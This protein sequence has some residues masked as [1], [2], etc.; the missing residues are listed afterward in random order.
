VLLEG[1]HLVLELSNIR[2]TPEN[3]NSIWPHPCCHTEAT[4]GCH[5]HTPRSG[6]F[7]G[8]RFPAHRVRVPGVESL[9]DAGVT[10]GEDAVEPRS[11]KISRRG[12]QC[13]W[14]AVRTAGSRRPP[15]AY[16]ER[17]TVA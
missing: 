1:G 6:P 12:S 14:S 17:P 7:T 10:V 9:E 15:T 5:A 13:P 16:T 8:A 4:S 3:V 11:S 2:F